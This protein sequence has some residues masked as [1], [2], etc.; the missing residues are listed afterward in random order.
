MTYRKNYTTHGVGKRMAYSFD[1]GAVHSARFPTGTFR[2]VEC[3]DCKSAV[4]AKCR[5]K[6]DEPIAQVHMAR[7]RMAI[8]KYY[9]D[10]EAEETAL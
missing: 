6:E 7:R 2:A 9:A 1:A 4:G 8:R 10:R 3:P 5:N